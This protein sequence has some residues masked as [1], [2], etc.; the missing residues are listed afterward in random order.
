MTVQY[1]VGVFVELKDIL[2]SF[3]LGYPLSFWGKMHFVTF[4][5]VQTQWKVI[6]GGTDPEVDG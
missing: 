1:D 5:L 4:D 6:L 3:R 2:N